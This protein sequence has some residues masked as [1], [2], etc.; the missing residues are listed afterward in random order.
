MFWGAEARGMAWSLRLLFSNVNFLRAPS[1]NSFKTS[2]SSRRMSLRSS[3]PSDP[4]PQSAAQWGFVS[5]GGDLDRHR[6][7]PQESLLCDV[8]A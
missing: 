6:Y 2:R 1:G 7:A 5:P 4:Y 3:A 8:P